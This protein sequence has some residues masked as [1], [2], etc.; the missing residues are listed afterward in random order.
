MQK[1]QCNPRL[2]S[3][4]K[5]RRCVLKAV[6]PVVYLSCLTRTAETAAAILQVTVSK[7][8]GSRAADGLFEGAGR[9]D[10]TSGNTYDG[11]FQRGQIHGQGKYIWTD[12]LVYT[13]IF[14][15]NKISGTGV[16]VQ[17][18]LHSRCQICTAGDLTASLML[19][20]PSASYTCTL[21]P[22]H[23]ADIIYSVVAGL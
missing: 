13:G 8:E 10:F 1:N 9:A 6:A 4:L 20:D 12:G 2:W 22:H 19:T 23:A 18:L 7:Y 17:A 5:L 14:M 15:N 16:S 11:L 21:R 3:T